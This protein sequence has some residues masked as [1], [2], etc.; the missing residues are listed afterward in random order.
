MSDMVNHPLHYKSA[1]G[2]EAIDVIEA[3][4]L[5]FR[6]GNVIKYIL[7]KGRKGNPEQ[8]LRKARWYLD[9]AIEKLSAA[10]EES[11]AAPQYDGQ[12]DFAGSLNAGYEAIRER[13]KDGGPGWERVDPQQERVA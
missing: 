9:R 8:D 1:S 11:K 7:R 4:E 10:A 12:K 6:L 3:F 13:V 2:L 5:D